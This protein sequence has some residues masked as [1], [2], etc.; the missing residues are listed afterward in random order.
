MTPDA[1]LQEL[2]R[3]PDCLLQ[4]IDLVNRRGL[5]V[6]IRE[7]DYRNASFLDHRVLKPDTQGAWFPL[8]RL[9]NQAADIKPQDPAHFIFHVSH[10]GSTLVSR[11][12]AELPGCLPLREPL[13]FLNLAL[14]R[15]ELERPESRLDAAGWDALFDLSIR[16]AS[17]SYR[18]GERTLV[19]ATSACA[20]LLTPLFS[21]SPGSRALLLYTDLETWLT[22]MLRDDKVR[23]NGRYYAPAWLTDFMAITGLK[24]LKL[25]ALTDAEQ[26]ALNWLTGMLHF[27]RARETAPERVLL[28]DFEEFLAEPAASLRRA[29]NFFDLDA[30]RAEE[31]TSGSLMRSYA[32]NPAQPFNGAQRRQ[33]LKQAR[34]RVGIEIDAGLAFAGK[35]SKQVPALASL[36]THFNRSA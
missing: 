21:R 36:A 32:K 23:E 30:A 6:G 19:K 1:M 17:R 15:R 26:F 14:A 33:E 4:D 31:I 35:L 16:L 28:C 27:Q 13:S 10:C 29:A 20:N 34:A 24:D 22:T 8:P 12:L 2:K 7:A 18:P 3:S 9:I 11:L 5:L 25:S